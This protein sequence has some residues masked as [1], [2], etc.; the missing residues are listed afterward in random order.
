MFFEVTISASASG[1]GQFQTNPING[2]GWVDASD[3]Q[4][5]MADGVGGN[6]YELGV[7][8]LPD[9][10]EDIRGSIANEPERVFAVINRCEYTGEIS[11]TYCGIT[12]L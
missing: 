7:D 2:E 12:E 3:L 6:L 1:F 4:S 5:A 10:V 8:D 9:G 11:T